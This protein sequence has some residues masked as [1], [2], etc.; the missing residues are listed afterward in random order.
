MPPPTGQVQPGYVQLNDVAFKLRGPMRPILLTTPPPRFE[1]GKDISKSEGL[2]NVVTFG[3]VTG[4]IG[5]HKLQSPEEVNTSWISELKPF[6][7]GRSLP[8]ARASQSAV[9]GSRENRGSIVFGFPSTTIDAPYNTKQIIASTLYRI[10]DWSGAQVNAQDFSEPRCTLSYRYPTDNLHYLFIADVLAGGVDTLFRSTANDITGAFANL[11][12]TARALVEYDNKILRLDANYEC[13]SSADNG[14]TW[15]TRGKLPFTESQVGGASARVT[16]LVYPDTSG[17]DQVYAVTS[18]GLYI[19]DFS[20]ARWRETKLMFSGLRDQG[21][22]GTY[23]STLGLAGCVWRG[24]L[25]L[26]AGGLDVLRYTAGE[27]AV[28]S[29]VGPNRIDGLPDDY[30][31]HIVALA[32]GFSEL[33]ALLI[34]KYTPTGGSATIRWALLAWNGA[35]W[36]VVYSSTIAQAT[37]TYGTDPE[38]SR[39]SLAVISGYAYWV[40]YIS[41]LGTRLERIQLPATIYNPRVITNPALT[42]DG[43]DRYEITPWVTGFNEGR[44]KLATTAFIKT[45]NAASTR[46]AR[47]WWAADDDETTWNDFYDPSTGAAV[48]YLT[49]N[50]IYDLSF[51]TGRTGQPFDSLRLRLSLSTTVSNPTPIVPYFGFYFLI[52]P[53]QRFGYTFTIDIEDNIGRQPTAQLQRAF[54]ETLLPKASQNPQLVKLVFHSPEIDSEN[55]IYG[56]IT[57]LVGDEGTGH[58][59]SG[60][61]TISIIAVT[62]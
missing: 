61:Y 30:A 32:A 57:R 59:Y 26:T 33:Y 7:G 55:T 37:A 24:D 15:T 40:A 22:A 9:A 49:A 29:S 14:A 18:F 20:N 19:L 10:F 13:F 43:V 58:D 27:T 39:A 28:V 11:A 51:N 31:G 6:R 41:V 44:K 2:L 48:E 52:I 25:Y 60:R 50:N 45:L 56:F 17:N 21:N 53:R 46:R 42:A 12:V 47:L 16:L 8:E 36:R 54:L 38:A 34:R 62:P 4:G 3:A 5:V 35:A 1:I 23:N